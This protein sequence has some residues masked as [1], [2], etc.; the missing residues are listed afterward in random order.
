MEIFKNKRIFID[1]QDIDSDNITNTVRRNFDKGKVA[2]FSQINDHEYNKL[3]QIVINNFL[4]SERLP[5]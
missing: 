5:G 3:Q 2:I 1:K 4:S